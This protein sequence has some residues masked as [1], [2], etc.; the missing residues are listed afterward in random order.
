MRTLSAVAEDMLY[1]SVSI[2]IRGRLIWVAGVPEFDYYYC[3]MQIDKSTLLSA[4]RTKIFVTLL[5]AFWSINISCN[6]SENNVVN[7]E[8]TNSAIDVIRNKLAVYSVDSA[9]LKHEM[10]TVKIKNFSYPKGVTLIAWL[11]DGF[12]QFSLWDLRISPAKL[13]IY[14][15]VSKLSYLFDTIGNFNPDE[16][17][18]FL[19]RVQSTNGR[20]QPEFVYLYCFDDTS[21]VRIRELEDIPNPSFQKTYVKGVEDGDTTRFETFY[22]WNTPFR[23]KKDSTSAF[24]ISAPY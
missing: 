23:L 4:L 7:D 6:S 18:D 20:Y 19:V 16:N 8:L 15:S 21:F 14:D 9:Q 17:L 2:K 1:H 11:G 3:M 22:K 24:S 12:F 10:P 13:L 5:A